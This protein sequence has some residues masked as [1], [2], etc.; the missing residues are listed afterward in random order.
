[1]RSVAGGRYYF[2]GP[3]QPTEVTNRPVNIKIKKN[4]PQV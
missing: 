4:F 1:L 3:C 2:L